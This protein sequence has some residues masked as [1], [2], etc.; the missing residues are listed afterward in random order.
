[1]KVTFL[2]SKFPPIVGGGE[3]L[4][5]QLA[6]G[7]ASRG[8]K[9]TVITNY[10]PDRDPNQFKKIKIIELEGFNEDTPLISESLGKLKEIL[11]NLD[12]DILHVQNYLPF[13]LL[14]QIFDPSKHKFKV[15]WTIYN[16]P[17]LGQ[18][19]FVAYKDYG[20]QV[21]LAKKLLNSKDYSLLINTS[22]YYETCFKQLAGHPIKSTF[23]PCSIDVK[24]FKPNTKP[25]PRSKYSFSKDDKVILCT[26]RFHGRKGLKYLVEAMKY[27]DPEFKL[28]LTGAPK[29]EDPRIHDAIVNQIKE[30]GL[31]DRVILGKSVYS[32]EDMPKLYKSCDLFVM[33]SEFEGFGLVLLE[34]MACGIPVV[35]TDV[36]GVNEAVIDGY[37]GLLIPFGDSKAIAEAVQKIFQ[38]K[39]LRK[40]LIKQ[41][42][43]S[44]R[45]NYSLDKFV[46]SHVEEY[47]KLLKSPHKHRFVSR[48]HLGRF[49]HI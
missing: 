33:P 7:L 48:M 16:T 2:T 31:E 24:L 21:A 12:T 43:S 42:L 26:S 40:K 34:S 4:A 25:E 10:H 15:V 23:I 38:D 8:H 35:G 27:L 44:V 22:K 3:T 6:M 29:P 41:G 49:F 39:D 46:S 18:R 5:H 36:P 9:V 14:T 13:Y 1:M 30:L 45:K 28:L 32:Y 47:K 17:L 37:N 11:D 19:L 20:D